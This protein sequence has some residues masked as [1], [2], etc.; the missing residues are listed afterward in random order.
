[1][2]LNKSLLDL[3]QKSPQAKSP[4]A[5]PLPRSPA[6][7][8]AAG[9]GRGSGQSSLLALL[10]QTGAQDTTPVK[11]AAAEGSRPTVP[12]LESAQD[13]VA[14]LTSLA[15]PGPVE[16]P[17][18]NV[19]VDDA[20]ESPGTELGA[21]ASA[22]APSTSKDLN[23][24]MFKV[25][26]PF[27]HLSATNPKPKRAKTGSE[28][29]GRSGLSKSQTLPAVSAPV[30]EMIN[31][32]EGQ[33]GAERNQLL[34]SFLFD[35]KNAAVS[36]AP[37]VPAVPAEQSEKYAIPQ[38]AFMSY[39]LPHLSSTSI[40]ALTAHT[41]V[42]PITRQKR[43]YDP[44]ERQIIAATIRYVAYAL[45]ET[46]ATPGIRLID[47]E[48]GAMCLLRSEYKEKIVNLTF[49]HGE[50]KSDGI[51]ARLRVTNSVGAVYVYKITGEL[52]GDNE[53]YVVELGFEGDSAEIAVKPRARWNPINSDAVGVSFGMYLY[54]IPEFAR[55]VIRR[56]G[57]PEGVAGDVQVICADKSLKDFAFSD[58]GSTIATVDKLAI[59]LWPQD[60]TSGSDQRIMQCVPE[61]AYTAITSDKLTS[62][63]FIDVDDKRPA[64]YL[65]VGA[66]HNHDLQL[67]DI[68]LGTCV[69][70]LSFPSEE[71]NRMACV[72][73]HQATQTVVISCAARKSL[74]FLHL[75]APARAG[76]EGM[77]QAEYCRHV[78]KKAQEI[79]VH[80]ANVRSAAFEYVAEY[81]FDTDP[82]ATSAPS[83]C[84]GFQIEESYDD[85]N[86]FEM[87][88]YHEGGFTAFGCQSLLSAPAA[89]P[90]LQGTKLDPEAEPARRKNKPR[91]LA[92]HRRVAPGDEDL[93]VTT[94]ISATRPTSSSAAES[95]LTEAELQ[96][97]RSS[98]MITESVEQ[99]RSPTATRTP[100]PDDLVLA[101]AGVS[102][103]EGPEMLVEEVVRQLEE[104]EAVQET[105][106]ASVPPVIASATAT[107]VDMTA[108][109]EGLKALELN[110]Q[111]KIDNA[112]A[113]QAR[114][115]EEDRL[116]QAAADQARQETILKV[117]SE[118]LSKNTGKL[119]QTTINNTI[120]QQVL[121]ALS[122]LVGASLEHN[123][124]KALKDPLEKALPKELFAV[125]NASVQQALTQPEFTASIAAAVGKPLVGAV[126]T[127]FKAEML[128]L[129]GDIEQ[130]AL[131]EIQAV[132]AEAEQQSAADGVKIDALTASVGRM[133]GM[134]LSLLEREATATPAA[135][136]AKEKSEADQLEDLIAAGAW[137]DAFSLWIQSENVGGLF[138][139]VAARF[140]PAILQDVLQIHLLS[141]LHVV[142]LD[143]DDHPELRLLW[144]EKA[145]SL[146]KDGDAQIQQIAPKI[147]GQVAERLDEAYARLA[148]K[149]MRGVILRRLAAV[150]DKMQSF[151]AL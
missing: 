116:V 57:L 148:S 96:R 81:R 75:T 68:E 79:T 87:F 133:E 21:G 70:Q 91:K 37:L 61:L 46:S 141:F 66:R 150:I 44:T 67:W 59:K 101:A 39:T 74:Y 88:V 128:K 95:Q 16:P 7:V 54:N 20:P 99:V 117:V 126:E 69:Q 15:S 12:H 146:L 29:E 47:Q 119:I 104:K 32:H 97:R 132:R 78:S 110:L 106:S 108:V 19:E 3:L 98:I 127:S 65:L 76:Q 51:V 35:G 90:T 114:R 26:N 27:D 8:T 122:T 136:P 28:D 1:M 84:F 24:A 10:Q 134:L 112:F 62:V 50:G 83:T 55:E 125:I 6:A 85:A 107:N 34:D 22:A 13:L 9:G 41:E 53:P 111:T 120:Q 25:V 31:G 118:T 2:D 94:S 38:T 105:E 92:L 42:R 43:T 93:G 143:M 49:W 71:T 89:A 129:V 138:G 33:V 121:P 103:T 151:A 115:L 45:P 63:R 23:P 72:G 82:A 36:S 145:M 18:Y 11:P 139:A 17:K 135:M 149:G 144:F 60:A 140:Q 123:M 56:D 80:D 48:N 113:A 137:E 142:S 109:T 100:Q 147:L 124:T 5:S 14:K 131:R 30:A 4:I 77:S 86:A 52:K 73:Y 64:R 40:P 58:D 130:K 102:A